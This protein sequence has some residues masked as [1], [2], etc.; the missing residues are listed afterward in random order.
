MKDLIL[1]K[2][3]DS[4]EQLLKYALDFRETKFSFHL[5]E[6]C[7]IMVHVFE[8]KEGGSAEEVALIRSRKNNFFELDNIRMINLLQQSNL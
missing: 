2:V 7:K 4:L 5:E 3:S 1:M 6:P 8:Y